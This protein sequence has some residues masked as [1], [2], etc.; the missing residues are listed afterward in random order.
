MIPVLLL[1]PRK[2]ASR[3]HRTLG[4]VV[5]TLALAWAVVGAG[6]ERVLV[7]GLFKNRAM[8]EID[9][10]QRVLKA[11]QTSPEGVTLVSAD[12][13][14]AVLRIDG[15]ERAYT[16]NNK[17]GGRFAT[18]QQ[19]EVS[20]W[21]DPSGMFLTVGSVNGVQIDF[22]VD[23]GANVMAMSTR[24]AQLLGI[25]FR[26][27]GRPSLVRTASGTARAYHLGLDTVRVGA[28][29]V[30]NVGAVV[31]GGGGPEQVLLGM[32]FLSRVEMENRGDVLVLRA[33]F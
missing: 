5:L 15:A 9:G 12:S 4:T 17:I 7:L 20:I 22:L 3:C 33:K 31:I 6:G 16:L 1:Y 13:R 24:Q 26:G 28:I 19:A 32:S 2:P 30:H 27:G 8:L 29:T 25:D 11:G 10:A 18:P 21:R 23:T 14:G